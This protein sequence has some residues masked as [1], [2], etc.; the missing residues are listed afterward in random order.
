[1]RRRLFARLLLGSLQRRWGRTV[2][3]FASV[4]LA[5][6]LVSTALSVSAGIGE[7]TG[8]A[9]RAYGANIVIQPGGPSSPDSDEGYVTTRSLDALRRLP[10]ADAI[11]GSVPLL[12]ALAQVG[13][14]PVVLVGTDLA[15]ART[16][17]PWWQLQ[18]DVRTLTEGSRAVVGTDLAQALRL[19]VGDRFTV[20]VGTRRVTLA[21]AA[22]LATGGAE[23]NQLVVDLALA[24]RL[25]EKPG[26]ASLVQVSALSRSGDVSGIVEEIG[27]A[28][29]DVRVQSIRQVAATEGRLLRRIKLL[30]G[31][32]AAVVMLAAGVSVMA[33]MSALALERR[34]EVALMKAIGARE[35]M[36]SGLFFLEAGAI[37]LG[38]GLGGYALGWLFAQLVGRA[39]W[40]SSVPVYGQVVLITIA[41][42][43]ALAVTSSIVPVRR[44][45]AVEPAVV[46]R[47]E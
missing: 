19:K 1:M 23:D 20:R 11:Q 41:T 26:L 6:A 14:P 45:M 17:N 28:L 43:C 30:L 27:R 25:T 29:P 24:Q 7:R 15:A 40:A 3:A 5:S 8:R 10:S 22:I 2:V 4:T 46:L 32:I 36:V 38:G 31:L 21:V 44:A 39:M 34:G 12:F 13:S 42:A 33:T 18:P 35:G 9:L 16:V 47:G 37:G